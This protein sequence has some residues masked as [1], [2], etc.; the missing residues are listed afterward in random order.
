MTDW[1]VCVFSRAGANDMMG[2]V[3][4][5]G[6]IVTGERGPMAESRGER[7]LFYCSP[8]RAS[9]FAS[10]AAA[11]RAIAATHKRNASD[12]IAPIAAE[13]TRLVSREQ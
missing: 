2:S 11:W 6:F 10:R 3:K 7:G 5:L 9:V 4:T 1:K 13:I 12:G 8:S